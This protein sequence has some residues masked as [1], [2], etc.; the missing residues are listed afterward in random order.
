MYIFHREQQADS[1]SSALVSRK[2]LTVVVGILWLR[3][4]NTYS[5]FH[6]WSYLRC[7][8]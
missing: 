1:K 6:R 3:T 2:T 4:S 5:I 8:Y 7:I